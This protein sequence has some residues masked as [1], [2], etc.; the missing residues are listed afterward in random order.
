M[1]KTLKNL[2]RFCKYIH[3]KK[4]L[5][6]DAPT[7]KKYCKDT[8]CAYKQN[9]LEA[10]ERRD[11]IKAIKKPKKRTCRWKDCKNTFELQHGKELQAYCSDECRLKKQQ[12][13]QRIYREKIASQKEE[14]TIENVFK[15]EEIKIDRRLAKQSINIDPRFTT[16][17]KIHYEGL[18][19]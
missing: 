19:L 6:K 14:R 7:L 11:E 10:K 17:G 3:C 12:E 18:S 13:G 9:Q 8:D 2:P 1:D 5:P 15:E 16:R 4:L